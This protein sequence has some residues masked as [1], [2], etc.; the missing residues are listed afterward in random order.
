[1]PIPPFPPL[2]VREADG[3]PNLIPVYEISLSGAT[4]TR[5]GPAGVQILV[6]SGG[7]AG[8][9]YAATG[10]QYVTISAA[11]DLTDEYIFR[12]STGL[13]LTSAGNVVLV[14][15]GSLLVTSSRAVSTLFPMSGGGDLSADRTFSVNTAFLVTSARTISTTLPLS[16][17][18]TLEADRTFTI[19][20]ANNNTAGAIAAADFSL[21]NLGRVSTDR[22]ITTLFPMTGGGLNLSV[23]RTFSVN[24]AFLVTSNRTITAG[25]G[26]TGGGNLEADRTL[27]LNTGGAGQYMITSI[28]AAEGIAWINTAGAGGGPVYAPTGGF[29][30]TYAPDA[31]LTAERTLIAG[32]GVVVASDGSNFFTSVATNVRDKLFG[33]FAAGT[34]STTMRATSS[35]IFIPFNMQILS[36]RVAMGVS[37]TNFITLRLVQYNGLM[38]AS[39]SLMANANTIRVGSFLAIGSDT[40]SFDIGTLYAG[41]HLGFHVMSTGAATFGQD[42]TVTVICRTS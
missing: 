3:T 25:V 22:T 40:G 8:A 32:T 5:I 20:T 31:D 4:L 37:A 14:H 15:Y 28:G 23:D 39:T 30:V 33:F 2:R 16:G 13:S 42:M 17:G 1:M 27:D 6:D 7:G 38:T 29:Y 18:G 21:F 24:T 19:V 34:I 41:S 10:N 12:S 26:L 9:T 11:A 35:A 36:S